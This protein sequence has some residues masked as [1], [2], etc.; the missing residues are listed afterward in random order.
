MALNLYQKLLDAHCVK[1]LDADT[2]LLYVDLHLVHEVTS[3]QA[4]SGLNSRRL[5]V[6]R[7]ERIL[8]VED[9]GVPTS[10]NRTHVDAIAD[11]S[12]RHQI[13]VL[14]ENCKQHDIRLFSLDDE[15][16]GIVHVVAPE[17]GLTLP[18]STVACGDSHTSTHGAFGAMGLGIG[19]SDVEHVLATQCVVVNRLKAMRV[20]VNGNLPAWAGAKD[21]ALAIAGKWGAHVGTGHAV[22]FAGQTIR[23]LSMEGRMTLCNM[24]V[25]LGARVGMIAADATT[26][27]YIEKRGV[28]IDAESALQWCSDAGAEFDAELEI[29]VSDLAPQVTWGT[30][31][32]M[33]QSIDGTVPSGQDL[34]AGARVAHRKA[35]EYMG[36]DEGQSLT[37]VALDTVFIGSCTNSRI[38]DLRVAAEVVKGHSVA[39]HIRA[40][41]VPGSGL[42]KKQAEEEGLNRI[43]VDAG[44]EWRLPGC[45]MCIAMNGDKLQSG[46][47]CASTSNR[48]FEGRQGAGGRTHLCSPATAAASAVA[49]QLVDV[50]QFMNQRGSENDAV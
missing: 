2:L 5:P 9:H 11:P 41:V 33:A 7:P 50:R 6:R 19:T 23:D 32:G 14:R 49:G 40:Y 22:E 16:Q 21:I 31:P 4:F 38:E 15:R 1:E 8:A 39:E 47:R 48:N 13:A 17:Q 3:P 35:L 28:D 36:L 25:E 26:I 44:F 37:G 24:A 27:D 18:G 34:E 45:S 46:E 29:D 12:V 10:E 20:T 43:F 42:V 30:S